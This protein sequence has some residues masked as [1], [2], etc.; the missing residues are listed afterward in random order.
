[1]EHPW[2]SRSVAVTVLLT[3][4][5]VLTVGFGA[6]TPNPALGDYPGEDELAQDYDSYV[7]EYVQVTG[8]VTETDPVEI[9][10]EYEY[11]ANGARYSGVIALTVRNLDADVAVG[12]SLQVY[13]PLGPSK[14][15]SAEQSV[16][17]PATNYVAMYVV[18][19]LA[20]LWTLARLLCGW[21]LDWQT[22]ALKRRE[23]PWT[24]AQTVIGRIREVLS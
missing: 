24:P 19:A 18:S 14:T 4:L 16:S 15:I 8:T 20:G 11:A 6:A 22:A 2:V 7:G 5:F 1:M 23:E 12:E 3:V 10:V 21:R 13:G 17:V 9:D